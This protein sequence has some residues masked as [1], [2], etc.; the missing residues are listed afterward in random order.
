MAA[1]T[2]RYILRR[3]ILIT[4]CLLSI[5]QGFAQ[6][7]AQGQGL[8]DIEIKG[9][10]ILP[11]H[12]YSIERI[13]TDTTL[14]FVQDDSLRPSQVAR[15][16]LKVEAINKSRYAQPCLLIVL[17]NIDNTL[18]YFNEDANDW[19]AQRAGIN[20][21][22]DKGRA[23][24][25]MHLILQG[26][27]L[28]TLYVQ[29]NLDRA[30]SFPKA[31]KPHVVLEKEST[32]Q[33]KE[34]FFST[35]WI[36]S[37]VILLIFFLNNLHVYY[38]FRD[39]SVLFFLF[40]QLGGMMYITAYRSFFK[41]IFSFQPFSLLLLPNGTCFSY[42]INEIFMHLSVAMILYGVVQMTRSYL[43]TK[44]ALPKCDTWLQ[45]GLCGYLIFSVAVAVVN[46]C[47][48]YLDGYTLLYDNILVLLVIILLLATSIMAY[49]HKLPSARTYLFA[50]V[51][52]LLFIMSVAMYHVL[53]S[54]S[55]DGHLLLPDLV[56][57][58]QA[59]CFSIAIVS[60]IQILQDAL[61]AKDAEARQLAF[62]IGKRELRQRELALEN[63]QI[64][65]AFRE[66]ELQR[67]VSELQTEQ[68]SGDMLQQRS[69]NKDLQEKLEI[70][71]REL[72]SSTLYMV[73]KNAMLAELKREIEELN[74]LSPNNK[75]KE[76]S[77]IK[78]ILQS[79]LY[80]DEDWSRFKLHFEQV[81]PHFFEDLQAKYPTL[82][83]NELR[84]LSYF[85]INLST[86]EIVGLLNIDPASV[87]TAKTRLHKKMA[88]TDKGL[89][90]NQS[91]KDINEPTTGK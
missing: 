13:Q 82:T 83:K 70:N 23:K 47:G 73:Q 51:L 53:I 89:A 69:A 6:S 25:R 30:H 22:I 87:R 66:V 36:V 60:R 61:L 19:I 81:H 8:S 28:T 5:L 43:Q 21:T 90:L 67:K 72:A 55:N 16:W 7:S 24:G 76:L 48:F 2:K 9:Y 52:P 1:A 26:H 41:V 39:R 44:T 18:F 75:Q 64:Q 56:I 62:D 45:Y 54:F 20:V 27:T 35:A 29:V 57:V 49:R 32:I 37:L 77:R 38:R 31:I 10:G 12:N 91:D 42:D 84:L 4:I 85:H 34:H 79:N 33:E 86:K 46:L 17:P 71:Q 65:A 40:T 68:L 14:V 58:T 50:N 63:E 3:F 59:L 78:D 80:L 15:Y 88:F 74:K 11:D